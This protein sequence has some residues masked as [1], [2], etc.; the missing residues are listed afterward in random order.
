VRFTSR[1]SLRV[2]FDRSLVH[3]GLVVPRTEAAA[4]GAAVLLCL[5]LPEGAGELQLAARALGS[6]AH[7]SRPNAPYD[8][9]LQLLD[10][11]ADGLETLRAAAHGED[12]AAASAAEAPPPAASAEA[13]PSPPAGRLALG[14]DFDRAEGARLDELLKPWEAPPAPEAPASALEIPEAQPIP[15]REKLPEEVAR[16]LTEFTLHLIRAITKSSYYT[17]EHREAEQAKAGLYAA[18]TKLVAHHPE[19]TFHAHA[20]EGKCSMLVYG[21]F[22]EPTDLAQAM[23]KDMA[24]MYVP[25]FSQYFEAN[26]LISISFK[27]ALEEDEFYRFVDLLAGP[28]GAAHGAGDRAVQKLAELRIHHISLVVQEDRLTGRHLSWR[29]EMALTRLKKDLSTIPLYEHLGETELQRVR[30]QVFRDVVRPLRQVNLIRELLENCDL[31]VAEVDELSQENLAEM[32]AHILASVT[33][34]SLPALL[35]GLAA[36][37]VEA[38]R[39]GTERMAQLLRLVRRVVQQL[40]REQVEEL[41]N[42]FRLL[43]ADGALAVEEL[44]AF[45]QQKLSIEHKAQVFLEVQEHLLRCFD[46]EGDPGTY[47]K[48]L[49]LFETILPELLSPSHLPAAVRV[50]HCV[51]HHCT[52]PAPF[53]ERG[54]LADAWLEHLARTWLGRKFVEQ[55]QDADRVNRE[56]LFDFARELGNT[57]VALLF[58]AL[59]NSE[60]ASCRQDLVHTLAELKAPSLHLLREQMEGSDLPPDYLCDL[61]SILARVGDPGA[62]ELAARFL[63][64]AESPVRMQALCAAAVLDPSTCESWALDALADRDAYIQDAALKFLFAHRSTAPAL[65][66]FCRRILSNLDE[67]DPDMAQRICSGVAGYE[68]GDARTW[69]VALL[70]SVVEGP[71]PRGPGWWT[72]VRRSVTRDPAHLQL[73]IAACQALGRMGAGEAVEVLARL[74]N[75]KNPALRHAAK[76]ALEQ[77]ADQ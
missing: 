41:E 67:A 62:V 54:E 42:A 2:Q 27:R 47:Q 65:F 35:E 76:H 77:I 51:S 22:D 70:L 68:S 59:R 14:T 64:H 38:K 44:P 1:E 50:I 19:I 15:T 21:V 60:S 8:V 28:G 30:L 18:F 9:Q 66:G 53:E 39:E 17:A 25:R 32:E 34:E 75:E 10:L 23:C 24:G 57:G 72:A 29:V 61:L 13:A 16:D 49:N 31:V 45:M 20:S 55:F 37:V 12:A 52:S 73:K 69:S 11:E 71:E 6:V 56:A 36:N 74:G 4:P 48:Y 26:G 63:E 58:A 3:H 46:S 5:V 33:G 43:H 7:P 40:N